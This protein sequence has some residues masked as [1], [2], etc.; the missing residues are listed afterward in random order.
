M[1][2]VWI[3]HLEKEMQQQ[4]FVELKAFVKAQQAQKHVYP[5]NAL[6]FNAFEQ[7]PWYDLKVVILGTEPQTNG[8]DHG[9]AYSST[10]GTFEAQQNIFKEILDDDLSVFRHVNYNL[11][12]TA[13]L[14]QW[15]KQGVL[16]LNVLLTA[17]KDKKQAHANKGW[18]TFTGNTLNMISDKKDPMV[19]MLWGKMAQEYKPFIDDKKHLVLEASHPSSYTAM[20]GFF[21]C[22]H[23]SQANDF[24]VK[25]Y[26]N[27]ANQK[28][29]IAWNLL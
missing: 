3:N 28:V 26:I 8:G 1:D 20:Q 16:L 24:I 10:K 21:G 15:A 29:G 5:E 22:K 13:N 2:S 23:F 12:K 14:I 11:F 18:E 17:E 27:K 19:F 7:C 25:N 4:Y 9:L 6:I